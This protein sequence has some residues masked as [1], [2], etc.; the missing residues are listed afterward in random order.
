MRRRY[1]TKMLAENCRYLRENIKDVC[2][3]ADVI[4]G[5][6]GETDVDFAETLKNTEALGLLSAHVFP[7][8]K[9][10]GTEAA[11]MP[12]QVPEEVK[13]KRC[14]ALSKAVSESQK[15]IVEG[16]VESKKP[17]KVL[18]ETYKDGYVFGHTENFIS[19]RAKGEKTVLNQIFDVI[20][21]NL[22][23]GSGDYL[24]NGVII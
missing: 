1:N 20:L 18:F 2:F 14:A 21:T 19:V 13:Q 9:R 12:D 17:F 11:T 7:F 8:S 10:P 23:D 6:P 22:N 15:A 16:Y 5:F 24:A 4:C 3:T